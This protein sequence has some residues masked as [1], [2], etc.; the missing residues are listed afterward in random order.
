MKNKKLARK[1]FE[2]NG[3]K[4]V[5]VYV[6]GQN[7]KNTTKEE[8]FGLRGAQWIGQQ[9]CFLHSPEGQSVLR[10]KKENCS[11]KVDI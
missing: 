9:L 5:V 10:K 2:N 8:N 7:L 6:Q 4:K 1:I 11:K 3:H